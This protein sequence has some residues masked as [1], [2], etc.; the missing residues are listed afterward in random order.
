MTTAQIEIQAVAVLVAVACALPGVFLILRRMALLSDAI[1][2]AILLGIVL[3]FFVTRDLS[4]PLLVVA[5]SATGLLTVLAVE[6]LNRTGRMREDAAIGLVFPFLFSLGVILISRYAGTVHLDTDAVLLG[7]LAF[8]PFNR[9]VAFGIDWG[10]RALFMM[11]CILALNLLLLMLFFKELKIATF[12]PALAAALGISPAVVH[13]GLMSSVSL[14]AVGSFDAVGSILVVALMIAPPA[15]AYLI[16]DRLVPLIVWSAAIGA[17]GA[18]AGY[19]IAH[20]LDASIA[21]SMASAAGLIFAAAFLFSRNQGLL[22]ATARR[23][24][25]RQLFSLH[26]LLI[27]LLHHEDTPEAMEECRLLQLPDHLHWPL[28]VTRTVVSR[29][30]AEGLIG[31]DSGMLRLTVLGR[32]RA[33]E[34]MV[35]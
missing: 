32:Q 27:H 25:Q 14:T 13:Y 28:R 29:A 1:S 17:A 9:F 4:S 2:H 26:L 30:E 5:A 24:R 33:R 3:A 20:A 15:T 19:W 11:A 34:A 18:V 22:A 8:A 31:L 12:D 35:I 10:P 7:E 16:T 6:L 23:H 21:G